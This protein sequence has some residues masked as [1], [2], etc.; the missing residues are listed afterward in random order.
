[1]CIGKLGEPILENGG[2]RAGSVWNSGNQQGGD[3]SN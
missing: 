3:T 2:Y 1:M